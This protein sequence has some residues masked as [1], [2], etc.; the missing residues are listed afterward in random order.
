[1]LN[2]DLQVFFKTKEGKKALKHFNSFID[3]SIVEDNISEFEACMKY[4]IMFFEKLNPGKD[5]IITEKVDKMI[6][7]VV[8]G[9]L[10]IT[11]Y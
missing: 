11:S 6:Y 10:V 1:M 4:Q 5:V 7:K 2:N 8:K 9:R 3:L